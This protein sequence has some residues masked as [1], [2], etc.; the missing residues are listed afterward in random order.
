MESIHVISSW[1]HVGLTARIGGAHQ[2]FLLIP[3]VQGR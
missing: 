3:V 1:K 2:E